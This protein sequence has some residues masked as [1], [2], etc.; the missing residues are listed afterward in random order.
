MDMSLTNKFIIAA[1][2]LSNTIF[3]HSL[4]YICDCHELGTV[5][6]IVNKKTNYT[7]SL[8]FEYLNMQPMSHAIN[9]QPLMFGGPMQ[10]ERGFVIHK[11]VGHWRSSLVLVENEVTITTSNDIIGAISAG[12][13]PKDTL[14]T[15]GYVGW[16]AN[17]LEQEIID[18]M[19]LI[20]PFKAELLYNVPIEKRWEEAALSIG[21]HM[22]Q[23]IL[24]GGHA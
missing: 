22:N 4:V 16:D 20:C 12:T 6:L 21:V 13:A 5:G 7:I 1:P 15:L 3:T 24:G 11:P 18:D 23:M 8:L 2:S 14:V 9:N 19:W 10:P 17:Q